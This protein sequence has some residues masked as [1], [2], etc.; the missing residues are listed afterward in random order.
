M[1]KL[2]MWWFTLKKRFVLCSI[3]RS[4]TS[5]KSCLYNQQKLTSNGTK[6][7]LFTEISN[8]TNKINLGYT[9]VTKSNYTG[10]A[11]DATPNNEENLSKD[12]FLNYTHVLLEDKSLKANSRD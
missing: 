11:L 6:H 12:F 7:Y 9:D 4:M 1:K 5:S 8:E 10:L 3:A 2:D